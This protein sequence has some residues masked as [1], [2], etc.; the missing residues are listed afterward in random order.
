RE[1]GGVPALAHPKFGGAE[2]L[3]PELVQEGIKAL[4]VYHPFHTKEDTERYRQLAKKYDLVEV[5]G[6]DSGPR[7]VGDVTVP[8]SAVNKLKKLA[9]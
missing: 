3:L 2:A 1:A 7:C 5:G 9:K 6:T 4:E 8:Y